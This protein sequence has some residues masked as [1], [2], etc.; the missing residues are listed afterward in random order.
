[1]ALT[2]CLFCD[3]NYLETEPLC[4]HCGK[5]LADL[6]QPQGEIVRR[7]Y[8]RA[9]NGEQGLITEVEVITYNKG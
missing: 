6:P 4:P 7:V 9:V 1:M 2:F 5:G 3:K 8:A